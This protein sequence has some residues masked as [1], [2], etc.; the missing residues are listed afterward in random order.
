MLLTGLDDYSVS[1]KLLFSGNKNYH[2]TRIFG[3]F[4]GCL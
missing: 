4:V 3:M 1:M 2:L